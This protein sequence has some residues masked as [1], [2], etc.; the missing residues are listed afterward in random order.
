MHF[1]AECV[2][3]VQPDIPSDVV[4]AIVI[5]KLSRSS[6]QRKE[7]IERLIYIN[8]RIFF[9]KFHTYS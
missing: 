9:N 4:G 6:D 2:C 5:W 1:L 8:E 7:R 3:V